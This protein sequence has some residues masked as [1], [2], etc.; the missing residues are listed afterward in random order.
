[1]KIEM[2]DGR[3]FKV[4][5]RY[6]NVH[7]G[8]LPPWCKGPRFH[9]KFTDV[10]QMTTCYISDKTDMAAI[11]QTVCS[12]EDKFEKAVG[13]RHALTRAIRGLHLPREQRTK[14]WSEYQHRGAGDREK[15]QVSRQDQVEVQIPKDRAANIEA[16][17]SI[18]DTRR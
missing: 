12:L 4:W 13:R 9:S 2:P 16:A 1:M 14:I 6:T 8:D 3:I 5:F 7:V 10:W 17:R 15:K 11:G 18:S